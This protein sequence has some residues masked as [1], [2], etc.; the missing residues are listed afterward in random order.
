M[1][2]FPRRLSSFCLKEKLHPSSVLRKDVPEATLAKAG[3]PLAPRESRSPAFFPGP[4]DRV[5]FVTMDGVVEWSTAAFGTGE[6]NRL[7]FLRQMR[8]PHS[9]GLPCSALTWDCGFKDEGL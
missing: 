4:M 3:F 5:A 7:S 9:L 2:H 8:F 1:P 6:R